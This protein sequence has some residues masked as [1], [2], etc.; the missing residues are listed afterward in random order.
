LLAVVIVPHNSEKRCINNAGELKRCL[1]IVK[2]VVITKEDSQASQDKLVRLVLLIAIAMTT[3]WLQGE[4]TSIL[5]T[6]PYICR[7]KEAGRTKR[8]HSNFW[9]GLYGHNWIV[10]FHECEEWVEELVTSVRNKRTF[11][12]RGLKA[13]TLIQQAL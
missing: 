7:Q 2:L 1:R 10:A 9:V 4:K 12:Q 6:S 5:M 3:A 13:L 11:Y 8:R